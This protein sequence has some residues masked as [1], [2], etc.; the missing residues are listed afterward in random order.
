MATVGTADIGLRIDRSQV[1]KEIGAAGRDIDRRFSATGKKAGRSLTEGLRSAS[2]K[3][4]LVAAGAAVGAKQ[5]A[6]AAVDTGE[7]LNKAAVVFGKS[8][9]D[10]EKFAAGGARSLGL[11]NRAALEYTGTLGNLLLSTGQTKA[12][13][14][15]MS[16]TMVKLAADLGSF[17]NVSTDDALEAIR[18]GLVGETEPLKRFGVNLND[19]TLKAKAMEMGLYSGKGVLDANAKAQ[20]SYAL[21][22]EQTKTAQGD[23]ARTSDSVANKQKIAAAEF[24]NAKAKLGTSLIPA[25]SAATTVATKL[26]AGVGSLPPSLAAATVGL[27]AAG[28]AALF[29]APKVID[30]ATAIKSMVS[31][32]G[33]GFST[34]NRLATG[35]GLAS[36]AASVTLTGGLAVAALALY[37]FSQRGKGAADAIKDLRSQAEAGG[38]SLTDLVLE[39]VN[40]R[41]A[42]DGDLRQYLIDTGTSLTDLRRAMTGSRPDFDRFYTNLKKR[43]AEANID[44]FDT[45]KF[46]RYIADQR[47]ALDTVTAEQARAKRGAKELGIEQSTAAKVGGDAVAA[48]AGAVSAL[49]TATDKEKDKVGELISTY[50]ALRTEEQKRHDAFMDQAQAKV[51]LPGARLAISSARDDLEKALKSGDVQ[52]QARAREALFTATQR[53][54]EVQRKANG[55]VEGTNKAYGDQIA[56]FEA[57]K[58]TLD[59]GEPL[60]RNFDGLLL[61][62]IANKREAENLSNALQFKNLDTS[63]APWLRANPA[64]RYGSTAPAPPGAVSGPRSGGR[65]IHNTFKTDAD[66]GAISREQGRQLHRTGGR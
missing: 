6:D 19:A 42:R 18:S 14:A 26:S 1:A 29:L 49:G 57:V 48:Q 39:N 65:S 16:M 34:L 28:G 11:S 56:V 58:R 53:Y 52:A 23:F 21:I 54:A 64:G 32:A 37:G 27:T 38:G 4:G 47:N 5:F 46:N 36:T 12:E 51:E 66:A 17:N 13:A 8:V 3:G 35:M 41:V 31:A 9:G 24:D 62:L 25:Y 30:G 33:T 45:D 40:Q 43:A 44:V 60:R 22:L 63:L 7:S 2:V 20:A 55:V 50:Q 10:V 61:Q 59:P 15:R